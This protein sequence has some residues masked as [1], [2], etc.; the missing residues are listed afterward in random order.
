MIAPNRVDEA[1]NE[2]KRERTGYA[3]LPG[4]DQLDLRRSE[5]SAPASTEMS[6]KQLAM[7]LPAAVVVGLTLG[8]LVKRSRLFGG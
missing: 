2:I 5:M 4:S 3:T 6:E 1:L 7:L 8:W